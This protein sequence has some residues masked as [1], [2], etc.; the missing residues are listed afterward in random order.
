MLIGQYR[1]TELEGDVR[2]EVCMGWNMVLEKEQ[3]RDD[4]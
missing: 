3:K 4:N 2:K 1:V